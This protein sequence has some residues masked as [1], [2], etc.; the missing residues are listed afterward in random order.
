MRR[1]C[2]SSPFRLVIEGTSCSQSIVKTA[3]SE[4]AHDLSVLPQTCHEGEEP[5]EVVVRLRKQDILKVRA[6]N[7]RVYSLLCLHNSA[8]RRVPVACQHG[9]ACQAQD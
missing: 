6:F 8:G 4:G 2:S 1:R 5:G 9:P 7:T 3:Y